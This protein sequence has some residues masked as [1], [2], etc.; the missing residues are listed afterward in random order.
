V[1]KRLLHYILS[2]ES[3]TVSG[4]KD[5]KDASTAAKPAAKITPQPQEEGKASKGPAAKPSELAPKT[6]LAPKAIPTEAKREVPAVKQEPAGVNKESA[7]LVKKCMDI[8]SEESGIASEELTDISVLADVGID[9]L[10]SLMISSR[11]RDELDLE[12]D[13]TLFSGLPTVKDLKDL[14]VQT[15]GGSV[16]DDPIEVD[17]VPDSAGKEDYQNADEPPVTPRAPSPSEN[18]EAQ[19]VPQ[20]KLDTEEAGS[21]AE[22]IFAPVLQIISEETGIAIDDFADDTVFAD[23]GVDSL[24]SLMITSRLRDE[25][26]V[27]IT[28]DG[29]LFTTCSTV[30]ILRTYLTPAETVANSSTAS[31]DSLAT[32]AVES[33]LNNEDLTPP[34]TNDSGDDDYVEIPKPS[35]ATRRATSII[36][37]G[38]PWMSAKTL[39]LLPD[40]A[41]SATSYANLPKIHS[42]VSVIGLNCPYFRHPQ[43][44][45]CSLDELIKSYLDEVRRRQPHGPYSFGGWS[46]GGILAYRATQ[47][48][49]AEGEEV[50]NLVLIDSPEPRG[51]DRLPQRFYDHCN[52]IGLFGKGTPGPSPAPPAQL[53]EHFNATIEVLHSYYAKPLPTGHLKKVAILWATECV[54]DGVDFPKL[55]PGPED[56]EGMRFLTEQ[57]TEFTAAGWVNLFPGAVVDIKRV[58][59]AHHF[60][61]MVSF[62]LSFTFDV[63]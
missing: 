56:T 14:L 30:G 6:P 58:E 62:S 20:Q 63:Y 2:T 13:S 55:P 3:G 29:E 16:T 17:P 5:P 40:G 43:E 53:F 45:T 35:I 42:D 25:L 51:L 48:S 47:I 8:V 18:K 38:R 28:T 11:F 1:A 46:A 44:M 15:S 61:M 4:A 31:I 19:S 34:S 9:S 49:I 50:E 10:L 26:D 39:F 23:S 24:L 21:T 54:M 60:S 27:E 7:T 52:R 41:G 32:I 36:L 37:Q 22:G 57:R 33:T 12:I 59:G